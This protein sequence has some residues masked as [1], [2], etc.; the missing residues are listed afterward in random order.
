MISVSTERIVRSEAQAPVS[1]VLYDADCPR[2][3]AWAARFR[4]I[5][6]RRGFLV[7]PLQ[8]LWVP[9]V[10]NLGPAELLAEMRVLTAHGPALGGAD[11]MVFLAGQIWW[12]RPVHWLAQLPGMR[13]ILRAAYRWLAAHRHCDSGTCEA[14]NARFNAK[15]ARP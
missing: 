7:A 8:S 1:W 15:G 4:N 13:R 10:L 14:G 6:R 2:C 5:L 12:A 3:R 11:A 9:A